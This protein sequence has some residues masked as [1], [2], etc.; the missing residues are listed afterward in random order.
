LIG[1]FKAAPIEAVTHSNVL[2]INHF[3]LAVST[4]YEKI[5]SSSVVDFKT[6]NAWW[7]YPL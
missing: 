4:D 2:S 5:V 1:Y 6:L 7:L 3:Y